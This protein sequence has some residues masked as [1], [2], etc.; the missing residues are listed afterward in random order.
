M[1]PLKMKPGVI[2]GAALNELFEYCKES[3]CALPAVNVIGSHGVNSALQAAREAKAPIIIQLSHSGA[4][5]YAGKAIDNSSHRASIL[6]AV[7]G[8]LH[9]RTLAEAYG[10]PAV[11]HTDHC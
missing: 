2:A 1:S 10:V 4:Q 7:A 5:F 9:A 3:G 11:L 8:A 6:G